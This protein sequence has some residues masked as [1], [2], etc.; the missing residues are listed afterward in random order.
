MLVKEVFRSFQGEGL[1][2]GCPAVFVRFAGCNLDCLYCDTDHK[3]GVEVT[4]DK[5]YEHII[6]LAHRGDIVVFTGGEPGLQLTRLLVQ[7]VRGA[8]FRAH[9]ETNGTIPDV[10]SLGLD[11]V[12][13]SPKQDHPPHPQFLGCDEVR[14]TIKLGDPVPQLPKWFSC[15]RKFLTPMTD[16]DKRGRDSIIWENIDY[17]VG[18]AASPSDYDGIT[19]GVSLQSHKLM[20][21]R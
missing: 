8:G 6:R 3:G 10:L 14:C 19:W 4:E 12:A 18:V 13:C 9:I 11:Y 21:V 2:T 5:L 16:P 17:C 7:R 20:G 1:Y 15:K